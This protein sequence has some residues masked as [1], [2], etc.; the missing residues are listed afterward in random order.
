MGRTINKLTAKTVA[1]LSAPGYYGDGNGLWLQISKYGTK[2]WVYRFTLNSKS[3]EMG[4]GPVTDI[5]LAKARQDIQGYRDQVRQGVDPIEARKADKQAKQKEAAKTKT[6][7][8]CVAS[9]LEAKESEWKNA[10]H[11]Q[12]WENTLKT[13][14]RPVIGKLSVAD[15]DTGL[16]LKILEPI[17]LTKTETATR[18]RGR[19]ENVLD[20]ATT[21]EYRQGLNP[22]RWRGHLETLL[23]KPSKVSKID[24]H[25]AL[26][27]KLL[28]GF[29]KLLRK[30]TCTAARA[31]EFTILVV[32]RTSEVL[33]AKWCEIDMD[34][35]I[36]I[37]PA[38]RMKSGKEHRIPLNER[39]I[40]LLEEMKKIKSNDYIFPGMKLGRPLSNM[41]MLAVLKRLER[42][43]LTTHGFRSTFRDWAGESTA[44]PREVIEHALAHQLKDKAE[45]AYARGTLFDKRKRLMAD[46]ANYCNTIQH[47]GR[48]TSIREKR[49]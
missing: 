36:W 22:A 45:A 8:E 32:A 23:P 37:I 5:F 28:G 9:F 35:K 25:A 27:F 16:V 48:V 24:H 41:S 7:D 47:N 44:Y 4:L 11:R 42:S 40:Q 17:W 18:V 3:R 21:R 34:E 6:F 26:P 19:I 33:N 20:W 10:K 29:V 43:D 2:N 39:A 46:W 38:Y 12:Q 30:E 31:L 1:A 13:Y 14:A 49:V 15:V